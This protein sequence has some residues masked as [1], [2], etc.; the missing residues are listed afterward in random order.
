MPIFLSE[1]LNLENRLDSLGVFDPLMDRDSNYFINIIRLRDTTVPEFS[2]AYDKVNQYFFDIAILLN[3][4][5]VKGDIAY[6]SAIKKF[7]FPEVNGIGLG[8]SKGL[9]GA[10]FGDVLRDRIICD[11]KEIIDLGIIEPEIFH[12]IGLFEDKVGP[13]KLSD[14]IARIIYS[15][16]CQF[17][18][19]VNKELGI[20]IEKY[21]EEKFDKTGIMISKYKNCEV[22]L[23]P[24]DILHELPIAYEWED[25]DMVCQANAAIRYEMNVLV[26][27]QWAK[28]TTQKKKKLIFDNVFHNPDI[29]K[30]VL[31]DYKGILVKAYDFEKDPVGDLYAVKMAKELLAQFQLLSDEKPT[32][33]NAVALKVCGIFK[34][35]I[36]NNKASDLLYVDGNPRNEKTV[37][38]LF[39]VIA[40]S[41]CDANDI[42]VSPESNSGRGPVDFKMSHG[43]DKTIVEIKLTTNQQ[44]L[45]GFEVQIEEY[46]KAEKT[47]NK[48]FLIVDNG[49][50]RKRIEAVRKLHAEKIKSGSRVSEVIYVDA[51]PK[52]SASKY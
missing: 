29:M 30:Q 20:T 47:D 15:E 17:T 38:L 5:K 11:A 12:L 42:D 35:L 3:M 19:R 50:P 49:G 24:K 1:E 22:L 44:L 27:N 40:C 52:N 48:I 8:F 2:G 23:L 34:D 18:I 13:D 21:P 32:T 10:G 36:E 26:G 14:M 51:R 28:L 6:R 4:S 31:A 39:Y 25:I 16:I 9:Y 45:H 33:S 7:D 37:Q 46:A 43:K 41:Y